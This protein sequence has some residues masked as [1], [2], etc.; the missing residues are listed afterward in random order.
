M[1][2]E[3]VFGYF[4]DRSESVDV[5]NDYSSCFSGVDKIESTV[6]SM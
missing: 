1:A 5:D 4:S 3:K 2:S 6:L